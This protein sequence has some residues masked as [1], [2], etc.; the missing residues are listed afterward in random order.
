MKA[1]LNP[2]AR[3]G[4]SVARPASA[5]TLIELLVVIA[6][7]AILAALLLPAL[8]KAKAKGQQAACM[9]NLRQIGIA[10]TM[11]VS[12]YQRYTGC[13]SVN[14][15][16]YY[17]WPVRLLAYMANNRKAFWCPAAN[18]NSAWDTN[19]NR[20][21]S[22]P[23]ISTLGATDENGRFDPYGI[24]ERSRFSLGINDWGLTS[25]GTACLGVGGDI[26]GTTTM[27]RTVVKES[28][29]VSP[30]QF[31]VV[32]DV[33]AAQNNILFNANMDPSDNTA[34]HTQRPSNRHSGHTDLM[35]AD[36]HV[37]KPRRNDVINSAPNWVWRS[38]WNN[39]NKPHNEFTWPALNGL[40][41]VNANDP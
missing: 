28:T 7:I 25:P 32:G 36:G 20:S 9:N 21:I 38:R 26:N 35:F 34:A 18:P 12:D 15:G 8:A 31:I 13:L 17:V 11:Y 10:N 1:F 27:S 23:N 37:E 22:N 33:P 30:T 41:G 6:I 5:F 4:R 14:H 19:A 2:R 40:T 29:V 16:Y 39:D 24:S 3:V